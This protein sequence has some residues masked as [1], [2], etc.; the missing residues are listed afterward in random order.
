MRDKKN[1]FNVKKSIPEYQGTLKI[2]DQ[3]NNITGEFS[4]TNEN[5]KK[6]FINQLEFDKTKNKNKVK[7][8]EITKVSL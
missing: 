1:I 6:L 8:V 3:N 7:K 4:T 2:V 5:E